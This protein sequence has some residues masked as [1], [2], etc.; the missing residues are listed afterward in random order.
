MYDDRKPCGRLDCFGNRGEGRCSVLTDTRF[1]KRGGKAP[2][3]CCPFFKTVKEANNGL[4][5]LRYER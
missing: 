1:S 4:M 5:Y 3:E 2:G